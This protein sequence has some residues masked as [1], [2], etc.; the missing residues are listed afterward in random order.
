MKEQF[1]YYNRIWSKC[2]CN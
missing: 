2:G 1:W